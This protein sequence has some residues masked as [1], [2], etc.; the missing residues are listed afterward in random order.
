MIVCRIK[1]KERDR[2]KEIK[3]NLKKSNQVWKDFAMNL[4]KI[5]AVLVALLLSIY[6]IGC[7]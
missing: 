2:E 1:E 7:V 3:L 4:E 5:T 6:A